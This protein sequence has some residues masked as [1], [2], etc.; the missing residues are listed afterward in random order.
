MDVRTVEDWFAA[1]AAGD[2]PLVA[3][4]SPRFKKSVNENGMTALMVAAQTGNTELATILL[5]DEQQIKDSQGRTALI[6]AI[7][8]GQS[9]LCRL[10]ATRELDT[11]NLKSQS[12]FSVAIQ[13]DAH[14]CLEAMLQAV[15]P[16]KVVDNPLLTAASVGCLRCLRILLEY[17]QCFEISEFDEALARA[18]E[19]G[20]A[21]LCTE[22]VSWK[23]EIADIIEIANRAPRI[24]KETAHN[25]IDTSARALMESHFIDISEIK[26]DLNERIAHLL[27]ENKE[28]RAMLK[29]LETSNKLLRAELADVQTQQE[30]QADG[31]NFGTEDPRLQ[32]HS[33]DAMLLSTD[34]PN[35]NLQ[36]PVDLLDEVLPLDVTETVSSS[37]IQAARNFTL[38]TNPYL[39]SR[40]LFGEQSACDQSYSAALSVEQHS[41][42]ED[43]DRKNT[44]AGQAHHKG[45]TYHRNS[46]N[47]RKKTHHTK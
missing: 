21:E 47:K 29:T 6:Y 12:P 45:P 14:D 3:G 4:Y 16:V 5:K 17:G 35:T 38:K 43:G 30:D 24:S 15:G 40:R 26:N 44:G 22:L 33:S 42:P 8:N 39:L 13:S 37:M 20:L 2:Q 25:T 31:D 19:L 9:Q 27:A 34:L 18:E 41:I 7:Q 32:P 36:P 23:H 11:S 1:V 28:L 46:G 10:L